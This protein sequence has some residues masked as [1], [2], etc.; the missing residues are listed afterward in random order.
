MG[1]QTS[2]TMFAESKIAELFS[3]VWVSRQLS[4]RDCEGLTHSLSSGQLN[5][6]ERAAVDRLMHAIRRGWLK[7]VD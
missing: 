3:Q 2:N 4:Q 1:V 6:E 7:V 5:F